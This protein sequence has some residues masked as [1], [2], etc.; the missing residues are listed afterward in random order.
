MTQRWGPDFWTLFHLISI[1][2]PSNPSEKDKAF[3]LKLIDS[4]PYTLP[5]KVCSKHFK[6]NLKKF[7]LTDKDIS[8]KNNFV[9]WMVDMHNTVN[10]FL[11]KKILQKNEAQNK[12]NSLLHINYLDHL[13]R[14]F[15]HIDE[16]IN[17][18]ISIEQ[19]NEIS[20]FIESILYFSGNNFNDI[21]ISFHDKHTF[22]NL[23]NNIF[24]K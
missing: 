1:N 19:C 12:I 5:C 4:I 8:S 18:K 11:K 15:N 14:I 23:K 3:L 17:D 7:P 6:E 22:K 9:T 10:I 13:K 20:Q 16:E 21:N 2:Y 24:K